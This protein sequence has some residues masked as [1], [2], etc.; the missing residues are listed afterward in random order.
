[1]PV[2]KEVPAP[3]LD[4]VISQFVDDFQDIIRRQVE[5]AVKKALARGPRKATLARAI[6]EKPAARRK[7]RS[8]PVK[9]KAA[10]GP[11][12]EAEKPPRAAS[13]RKGRKH[14]AHP[15]QLSLF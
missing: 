5:H 12:S 8:A 14:A 3:E 10:A 15:G 7:A 2:A 11:S 9:R 13:K 1:M 6:S 4:L